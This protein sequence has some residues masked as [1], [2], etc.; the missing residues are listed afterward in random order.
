MR[1]GVTGASGLIGRQLTA[2]LT[3]S[4]H[5]VVVIGR[6]PVESFEF[7]EWDA[8]KGAPDLASW[9][10]EAVVHLA[11]EPLIGSRWTSEKK[12]RIRETRVSGTRHLLEA[13][14]KCEDAALLI[15]GSA[16]GYY[17]DRGE[18]KL[19]EEDSAGSG[20]LAEVCVEWERE[21]RRAERLGMRTV[22]LRTGMVLSADGGALQKMLPPF[23]LG[24]GG[25]LGSGNQ[26]MSWIH[27]ADEV[28]LILFALDSQI[29]GPLNATAPEPVTNAEFTRQLS[30]QLH[31]PSLFRVPK[32]ALR[33]A[34]GEMAE[35]VLL[36]GQRVYP[37]K[38]T[39]AG[40]AFRFS[41]LSEALEDLL[42]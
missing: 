23:K 19:T 15:S 16:V 41:A 25:K 39:E 33:L 38:A 1:I 7:V 29:S 22:L 8:R 9:G 14:E 30:K 26:Y 11:G 42:E 36:G 3:A 5:E 27:M 21:A 34:M 17:G 13:L 6:T 12:R 40:Y 20:F 18:E 2:K 28:G 31:R 37:R 4:E 32:V 24:L 35:E 10:L